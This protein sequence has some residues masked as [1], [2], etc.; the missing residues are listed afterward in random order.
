M[1]ANQN[2]PWRVASARNKKYSGFEC[3]QGSLRVRSQRAIQTNI[4]QPRGRSDVLACWRSQG[5]IR[6]RLTTCRTRCGAG[7]EPNPPSM[8]LSAQ[9][10]S[11]GIDQGSNGPR[12]DG[13][14]RSVPHRPAAAPALRAP[15]RPPPAPSTP[16]PAGP[17]LAKKKVVRVAS[18]NPKMRRAPCDRIRGSRIPRP[19]SYCPSRGAAVRSAPCRATCGG[20]RRSL[21]AAASRLPAPSRNRRL[22]LAAA[23]R[24]RRRPGGPVSIG[25]PRRSATRGTLPSPSHHGARRSADRDCQTTPPP[26]KQG[27]AAR[28]RN[29]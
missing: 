19:V 26:Y 22:V 12:R 8:A 21:A 17:L 25:S 7:H 29:P 20:S 24:N 14:Y 4:C 11:T 6:A 23:S 9:T 3:E 27:P 16:R 13:V 28:R 2:I 1:C 15:C 18:L 5:G 10:F